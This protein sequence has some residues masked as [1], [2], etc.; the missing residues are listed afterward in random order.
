MGNSNGSKAA[1]EIEDNPLNKEERHA[2][3]EYYKTFLQGQS[4]RC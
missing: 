2:V 3:E 4:G 1:I